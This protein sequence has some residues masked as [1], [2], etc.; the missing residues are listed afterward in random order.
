LM[1]RMLNIHRGIARLQCVLFA[2]VQITIV[3]CTGKS[4]AGP[5]WEYCSS[6]GDIQATKM[7]LYGLKVQWQNYKKSA[8][9]FS[10][11][12]VWDGTRRELLVI[13]ELIE[14]IHK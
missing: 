1:E 14:R 6:C 11:G 8:F 2:D 10:Y 12:H 7:L 13:A 3:F 5:K 9:D 4:Y